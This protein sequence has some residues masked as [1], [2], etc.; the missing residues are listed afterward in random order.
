MLEARSAF[1]KHPERK[2]A[3]AAEPKP[4]GELGNP[5][6]DLQPDEK[7]A[8]SYLAGLLAPGVAKDMDRAAMEEAARLRVICRTNRATAAERLLYRNYLAAFGMTPADRSR[9][10]ATPSAPTADDPLSK[11]LRQ[12]K[13]Q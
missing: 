11:L 7:K 2:R 9:I 6:D 3:R 5:P 12:A 13:V 10:T 1:L 4:T 8:W